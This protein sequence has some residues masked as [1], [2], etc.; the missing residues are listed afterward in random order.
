MNQG[1]KKELSSFS[2]L[3]LQI[4][5]RLVLQEDVDES[6]IDTL[7]MMELEYDSLMK[8]N[9]ILEKRA[10]IDPKTSLLKYNENYLV[11][12]I[13]RASRYLEFQTKHHY[14][15]I[16]YLRID[17]DDFSKINNRY[18]HDIGDVVLIAVSEAMKTISRP[19]D[20]LFRFG[21]E[22]FDIV[23]PATA[24]EGGHVYA[25][26]L[27]NAI[28][29]ISVP[30]PSGN[31]GVTASVGLSS[32]S[33]DLSK[34]TLILATGILKAYHKVQKQADEACYQAKFDGKNCCRIF[35]EET[36]YVQIKKSYCEL[37]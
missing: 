32:F 30:T 14:M 6:I 31:I 8:K 35:N 34:K 20:Y 5:G 26:K 37:S 11:D 16:S 36:D 23:L 9:A 28:R 18:G 33:I 12:I 10:N 3:A 7:R 29:Q 1:S 24:L 15:N 21:G 2:L 4:M 25:D 17:L 27:L 22:E 19:T 13:K